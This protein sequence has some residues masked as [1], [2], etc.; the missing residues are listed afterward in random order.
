MGVAFHIQQA[1]RHWRCAGGSHVGPPS[2]RL[3]GAAHPPGPS[4]ESGRLAHPFTWEVCTG[5]QDWVPFPG[6]PLHLLC[7]WLARSGPQEVWAVVSAVHCAQP[8]CGLLPGPN[9][10]AQQGRPGPFPEV[11]TQ[12][13]TWT[14]NIC[15]RDCLCA[16]EDCF[17]GF[18]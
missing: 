15:R 14:P 12:T 17:C 13:R 8:G 1:P 2:A 16:R 5:P 11:S 10:E 7:E 6:V 18:H 3:L 9:A 4:L